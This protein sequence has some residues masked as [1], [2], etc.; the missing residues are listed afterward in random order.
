M[1]VRVNK[2]QSCETQVGKYEVP[3][4]LEFRAP[5]QGNFDSTEPA[6][7][8]EPTATAV[9]FV[10]RLDR[11]LTTPALLSATLLLTV[12]PRM[13]TSAPSEAYMKAPFPVD[14]H[15]VKCPPSTTVSLSPAASGRDVSGEGES[16]AH[17][18]HAKANQTSVV[19]WVKKNTA[20][21]WA[22]GSCSL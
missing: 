3:P 18:P 5:N 17:N 10:D 19:R 12:P 2:E 1:N 7:Y 15:P 16:R 11:P 6:T 21:E 8:M 4:G 9:V 20:G 14:R 22:I 13:V